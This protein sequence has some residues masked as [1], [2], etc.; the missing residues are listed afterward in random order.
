MPHT[1]SLSINIGDFRGYD[2]RV[3]EPLVRDAQSLLS[4]I[5]FPLARLA[6]CRDLLERGRRYGIVCDSIRAI[7]FT[8]VN[9]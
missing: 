5:L 2:S 3:Q 9:R 7:Q 4:L 6:W 8:Q 1:S